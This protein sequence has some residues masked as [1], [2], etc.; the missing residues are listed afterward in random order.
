[1]IGLLEVVLRLKAVSCAMLVLMLMLEL[2]SIFSMCFRCASVAVE[3]DGAG[4]DGLQCEESPQ[5]AVFDLQGLRD[6]EA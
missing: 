6:P 2:V 5:A 3:P 4:D 1:M